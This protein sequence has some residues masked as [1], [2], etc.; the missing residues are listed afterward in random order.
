MLWSRYGPA[1]GSTKGVSN[2]DRLITG[3]WD[4]TLATGQPEFPPDLNEEI[5]QAFRNVDICLRD[6]GGKGWS[7]V[8]RVTTYLLD[9]PSSHD[10][11]VENYRKWMPQHCPI[12]TEIGV[13]QLGAPGMRIE[14]E[15]VAFEP[16]GA[17][18]SK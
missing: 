9:I 11:I 18:G 12:W 15:V 10:R 1:S 5:D 16:H 14:I 3:G 17:V 6:A 13:R 4:A 7:Q 8:F 2:A